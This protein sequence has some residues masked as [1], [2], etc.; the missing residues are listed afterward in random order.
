MPLIINHLAHLT[1]DLVLL[2]IPSS[3]STKTTLNCMACGH[4]VKG[5]CYHCAECS[6]FFHTF[7][8]ALPLSMSL[9]HHPHKI[10]LEFSPPYDFL[11]D[12]CNEPSCQRGWLYRCSMCEFDTHIACAV[13]NVEPQS[14]Q[15]PSFPESNAL[16]KQLTSTTATQVDHAIRL[17]GSVGD[18][19]IRYE[20][21]RLVA[22]QICV[23]S[24]NRRRGRKELDDGAVAGWD[25]RLNSPRK[26]HNANNGAKRKIVELQ[27][28]EERSPLRDKSTPLSDK[29]I[30]LSSNQFSDSYF[31]IDLA[32]SYDSR[33]RVGKEVSSDRITKFVVAEKIKDVSYSGP[34]EE[35]FGLVNWPSN[36]IDS[37]NKG[38]RN[39]LV[40]KNRDQS[41]AKCSIQDQTIN[42]STSV[43]SS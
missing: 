14:I 24:N 7:C 34:V 42:K 41:L 18:S 25:K 38:H 17:S 26:K 11:C 31:S 29:S 15:H 3:S 16:L 35:P 23:G 22:G 2:A 13:E 19:S 43:S 36:N 5:F 21:M 12:L 10:Q 8:L 30:P 40:T 4:H 33:D 1:H 28:I 6:T 32:K 9:T 20:I 27:Y 37:Y 39:H